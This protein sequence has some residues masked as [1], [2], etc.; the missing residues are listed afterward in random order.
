[1]QGFRE[2]GDCRDSGEQ[3]GAEGFKGQELAL[4]IYPAR[5]WQ[6]MGNNRK[7]TTVSNRRIMPA[8]AATAFHTCLRFGLFALAFPLLAHAALPHDSN[9]PGGVA[10]IPLGSVSSDTQTPQTWLGD[11]PVLVTA[12]HDEWYAVVGLPLDIA[13]GPHQL[14]VKIGGITEAQDFVVNPKDYP[15]Q[16]ITLKDKSKVELSPADEARAEREIAG[17]IAL[18]HHW[19]TVQHPDLAFILP[20]KGELSSRFGLRRFFNGEPRAPHAGLDLA[21]PRG[22]PVR[23][24]GRGKVLA[25]GDYFFNG[26]TI[27]IDHGD[28]LITMYCHLNRIGVK[29]GEKVNRGQRIG[30]SGMTGRATGPH[31]H[32]SVILNGAMVDPELFIPAKHGN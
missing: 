14:R 32:W 18:K 9:V 23:A 26:K 2:S 22:T 10:V 20:A 12:D 21:V 19:R 7:Q 16:R 30:R 5:E 17:I 24:S 3:C 27:F 28:G 13:P 6:V 25:V 29:A 1:M 15:E 11:Q 8:V 31:L 4:F